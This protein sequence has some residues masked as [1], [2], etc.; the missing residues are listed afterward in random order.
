M[1]L[2]PSQAETD[3]VTKSI[4]TSQGETSANLVQNKKDEL[5]SLSPNG[6]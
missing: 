3:A 5:R 6:E 2:L 4:E 1:A